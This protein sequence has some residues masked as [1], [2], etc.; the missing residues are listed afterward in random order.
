[1]EREIEAETDLFETVSKIEVD[2]SLPGWSARSPDLD[3]GPPA[4]TPKRY[5][6]LDQ[7]GANALR[8]KVGYYVE[9]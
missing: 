2:R 3:I 5:R 6:G 1:M 7:Q 8:P 9:F 4:A